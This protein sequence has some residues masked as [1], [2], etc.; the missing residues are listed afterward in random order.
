MTEIQG[1]S[2]L[3]RVSEGSSYLEATV[4]VNWEGDPGA[5]DKSMVS[6]I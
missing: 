1:K 3:V 5:P 4:L 6:L 2:I